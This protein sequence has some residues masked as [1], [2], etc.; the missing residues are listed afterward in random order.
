VVDLSH[1]RQMQGYYPNSGLLFIIIQV[2]AQFSEAQILRKALALLQQYTR[3]ER[4]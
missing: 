2:Y 1:A 3:T 4:R